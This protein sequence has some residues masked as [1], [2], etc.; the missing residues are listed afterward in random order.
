MQLMIKEPLKGGGAMEPNNIV[1]NIVYLD[2]TST[3]I[4]CPYHDDSN[5][6]D[7]LP[8]IMKD[9]IIIVSEDVQSEVSEEKIPS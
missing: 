6:P 8:N 5:C 9:N 3:S 1:R 2:Y 4:E 7:G